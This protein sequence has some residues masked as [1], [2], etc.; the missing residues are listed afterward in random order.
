MAAVKKPKYQDPLALPVDSFDRRHLGPETPG[1]RR[2]PSRTYIPAA[3][4]CPVRTGP[5]VRGQL[6]TDA[7]AREYSIPPEL[8]P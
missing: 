5:R 7:R 6:L 4:Y 3:V 1:V 8:R 2:L